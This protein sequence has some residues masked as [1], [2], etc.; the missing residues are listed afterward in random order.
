MPG[1]LPTSHQSGCCYQSAAHHGSQVGLAFFLC[2]T[3]HTCQSVLLQSASTRSQCG[4]CTSIWWDFCLDSSYSIGISYSISDVKSA[5][6]YLVISVNRS[7]V[8]SQDL[9]VC[10]DRSFLINSDC[11][12]D[13]HVPYSPCGCQHHRRSKAALSSTSSLQA[14]HQCCKSLTA[15]G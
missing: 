11:N 15:A 14:Q 4:R 5:Q 1:H 2:I 12:A 6:P 9:R 3:P 10:P 7:S 13:Q 8:V